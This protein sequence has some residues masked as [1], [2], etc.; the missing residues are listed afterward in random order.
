[1]KVIELAQYSSSFEEEKMGLS[2]YNNKVSFLKM[3]IILYIFVV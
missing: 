1:M 2:I 3:I